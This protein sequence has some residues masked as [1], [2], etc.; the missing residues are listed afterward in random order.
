MQV[1]QCQRYLCGVED[2]LRFWQLLPFFQELH[3]VTARDEFHY[4]V[5]SHFLGEDVI[6]R[7]DKR[8]LDLKQNEFLSLNALNRIEL[9]H[10]VF[11]YGFH[12][13]LFACDLILD[14]IHFAKGAFA[15]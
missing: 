15:N 12:G 14:E 5:D 7:D 6:H 9:N 11:S 2:H 10:S 3:Q 13:I 1:P 4:K 8:V